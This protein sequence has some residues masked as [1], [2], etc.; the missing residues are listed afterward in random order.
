MLLGLDLPAPPLFQDE[1]QQNM[2]PQ[3]PLFELLNKFN[4]ITEHEYKTYKVGPTPSQPR[5]LALPIFARR[6]TRALALASNRTHLSSASSCWI[7]RT[8]L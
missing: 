5:W 8:T 6:L 2:I 3:V 4:G 7:C 1:R